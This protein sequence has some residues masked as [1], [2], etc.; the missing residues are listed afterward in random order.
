MARSTRPAEATPPAG[1]L[2]AF[3]IQRQRE[4]TR[5]EE[6]RR[7]SVSCQELDEEWDNRFDGAQHFKTL[8]LQVLCDMVANGTR[9]HELT[10]PE[11]VRRLVA[12]YPKAHGMESDDARQLRRYNRL[13][14]RTWPDFSW[15]W[16]QAE[17]I[18]MMRQRP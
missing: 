17:A 16:L 2:E 7:D 18:R 10:Q 6:E 3:E 11:A 9:R 14:R 1:L 12:R 13:A 15:A 5:R 4:F 8:M